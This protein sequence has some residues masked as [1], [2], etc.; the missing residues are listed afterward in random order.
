MGERLGNSCGAAVWRMALVGCV[1]LLQGWREG[2][3]G[4]ELGSEQLL[5]LPC[6]AE[7]TEGV[8]QHWWLQEGQASCDGQWWPVQCS[9][10]VAAESHSCHT[11]WLLP[12]AQ[13][14]PACPGSL[15]NG[16]PKGPAN[17]GASAPVRYL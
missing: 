15:G 7:D 12:R 6:T 5:G 11:P 4:R 13:L 10:G 8:G 1:S 16:N 9:K 2:K 17:L 3:P 14:L